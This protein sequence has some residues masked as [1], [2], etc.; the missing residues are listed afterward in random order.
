MKDAIKIN[1][2]VT[3]LSVQQNSNTLIFT[4]LYNSARHKP[5]VLQNRFYNKT[6]WDNDLRAFC[7]QNKI[8]YQSFWTLTANPEILRHRFV[9]QV[10]AEKKI[11]KEQLLYKFLVDLGHQPLTGCTTLNHVQEAVFVKDITRL[12]DDVL[13]GIKQLI[14][15]KYPISS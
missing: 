6:N 9:H 11:T 12:E 8:V 13:R 3:V 4:R 2:N 10:A 1:N 7:L 5:K 14:G 15:D